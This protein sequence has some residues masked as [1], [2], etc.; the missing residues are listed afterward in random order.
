MCIIFV[1]F[2]ECTAVV[3]LD[4]IIQKIKRY[5]PD[6]FSRKMNYKSSLADHCTLKDYLII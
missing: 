6:M 2:P 3:L 1:F 5:T 4:T